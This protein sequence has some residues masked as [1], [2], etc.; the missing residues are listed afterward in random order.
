MVFIC[1]KAGNTLLNGRRDWE[2]FVAV[3]MPGVGWLISSSWTVW[4][5]L[6]PTY[7]NWNTNVRPSSCCTLRSQYCVLGV[8]MLGAMLITL[9]GGCGAPVPKI[10]TPTPNGMGADGVIVNPPVF[11]IGFC[12]RATKLLSGM[13]SK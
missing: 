4:V 10:G 12:E 5:L 2:V 7:P 1:R 9:K 6:L 8:F 3:L 13:V 11:P